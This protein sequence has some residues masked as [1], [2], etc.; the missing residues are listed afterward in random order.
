MRM[1]ESCPLHENETNSN[2]A[3]K[4]A[5]TLVIMYFIPDIPAPLLIKTYWRG[6]SLLKVVIH[7]C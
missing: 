3:S 4:H 6:N 1:T 2:S 5:C 7:G